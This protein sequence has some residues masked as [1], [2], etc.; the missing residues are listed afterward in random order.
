MKSQYVIDTGSFTGVRMAASDAL[1]AQNTPPGTAWVDGDHNA[2]NRRCLVDVVDEA[3]RVLVVPWQ[4]D[5]PAE[6]ANVSWVWDVDGEQWRPELKLPA[7]KE[8]AKRPYLQQ[9]AALDGQS[10]RAVAEI[11]EAQLAGE[12]PPA[13]AVARLQAVNAEK[14]LTRAQLAAIDQAETAADLPQAGG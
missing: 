11:L 9:L 10:S 3:G 13:P 5:A 1:L 12:E 8:N 7:L 14:A 4:P 2:R 6:T